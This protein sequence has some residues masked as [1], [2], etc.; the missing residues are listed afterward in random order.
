[1]EWSTGL[2]VQKHTKCSITQYLRTQHNSKRRVYTCTYKYIYKCMYGSIGIKLSSASFS[3][4]GES[5]RKFNKQA[6]QHAFSLAL[7]TE[8]ARAEHVPYKHLPF[9]QFIL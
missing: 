4:A 8:P 5:L 9:F 3:R 2:C 1:M 7:A 6:G